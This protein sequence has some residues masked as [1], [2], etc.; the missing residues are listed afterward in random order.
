MYMKKGIR[1]FMLI[2]LLLITVLS[3]CAAGIAPTPIKKMPDIGFPEESLNQKMVIF[4][5]ADFNLFKTKASIGFHVRNISPETISFNPTDT[6]MFL[7]DHG[8]WIEVQD[9][10]VSLDPVDEFILSPNQ[11]KGL[12]H[13]GSV[14]VLPKLPDPAQPATLRIFAFGFIYENGV[15]TDKKVAAYVDVTLTP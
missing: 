15:K 5:P 4:A 13:D 3:A 14:A 1:F 11:I 9:Q 6:R 10:F 8:N 2:N 7:F 12:G